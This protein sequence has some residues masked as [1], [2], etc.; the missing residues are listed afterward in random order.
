MIEVPSIGDPKTTPATGDC[1]DANPLPRLLP[2]PLHIGPRMAKVDF[3]PE[4][5]LG[6]A[7]LLDD[8]VVAIVLLLH[9][10]TVY[11]TIL[12]SWERA[13]AAR[14]AA[15]ASGARNAPAGS[16]GQ[17]GSLSN[18]PMGAAQAAVVAVAAGAAAT[19]AGAGSGVSA[20]AA[21]AGGFAAAAAARGSSSNAQTTP[22]AATGSGS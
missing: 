17:G 19:F 8:L 13:R 14:A 12:L 7:G 1:S 15:A 22:P 20:F 18:S 16:P 9:I 6:F 10:T 4:S 5:L 11:R 3:M 21:A 2:G